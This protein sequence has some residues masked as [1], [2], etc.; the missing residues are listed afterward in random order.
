MQ[1]TERGFRYTT[2]VIDIFI[3]NGFGVPLRNQA[4]QIIRKDFSDVIDKYNRKPSQFEIDDGKEFIKKLLEN[5]YLLKTLKDKEDAKVKEHF[6]L[7]DWTEQ[8]TILLKR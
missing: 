2:V 1:K 4:A 3:R 7:K 8:Y 5:S 6:K